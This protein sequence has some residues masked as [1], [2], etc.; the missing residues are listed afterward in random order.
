MR[1]DLIFGALTHVNN[2]YKLCQLDLQGDPQRLHKP[3]HAPAGYDQRSA[4]PFQGHRPHGHRHRN[5]AR[6]SHS[7]RSRGLSFGARPPRPRPT[8]LFPDPHRTSAKLQ[9]ILPGI[10]ALPQQILRTALL[11]NSPRNSSENSLPAT[12]HSSS[13][14]PPRKT[15]SFRQKKNLCQQ[16]KHP[17]NS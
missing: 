15:Q 17:K 6:H 4:R 10:Q 5:R 7:G 14:H 8:T 13:T 3:K 2:R 9:P 11:Q 12:T 16:L 1:S